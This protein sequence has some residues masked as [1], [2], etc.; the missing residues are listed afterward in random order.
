MK[1]RCFNHVQLHCD[2]IVM[3]KL[4]QALHHSAHMR[5]VRPQLRI[6]CPAIAHGLP[7]LVRQL[8]RLTSRWAR[9]AFV[10]F[11]LEVYA[12]RR[13]ASER[14]AEG[15]DLRERQSTFIQV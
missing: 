3:T 5:C 9:Q 4:Q 13:E 8:R 6:K 10:V 7:D 1:L 15:E 11:K 12:I 2:L 14:L